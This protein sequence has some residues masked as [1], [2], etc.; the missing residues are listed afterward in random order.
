M[1]TMVAAISKHMQGRAEFIIKY[2]ISVT[3]AC[4]QLLAYAVLLGVAGSDNMDSLAGYNQLP[5]A[6]F[7]LHTATTTTIRD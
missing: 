7:M 5:C 2:L 1:T 3:R 6:D 4:H